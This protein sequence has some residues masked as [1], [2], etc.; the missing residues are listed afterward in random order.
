MEGARGQNASWSIRPPCHHVSHLPMA[1]VVIGG[2]SSCD[3]RNRYFP[4]GRLVHAD[5][6]GMGRRAGAGGVRVRGCPVPMWPSPRPAGRT[7]A[8][9]PRFFTASRHKSPS[10]PTACLC[11]LLSLV[12]RHATTEWG[13]SNPIHGL[14]DGASS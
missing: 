3:G 7:G 9:S 11:H 4:G 6:A 14:D 13:E 8:T 12:S 10:M 2:L 5:R 1:A